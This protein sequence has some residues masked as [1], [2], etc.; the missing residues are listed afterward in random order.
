MPSPSLDANHKPSWPV[1]MFR[2]IG[3]RIDPEIYEQAQGGLSFTRY[4]LVKAAGGKFGEIDSGW[5]Q[6]AIE[7]PG[8]GN[9]I[10][11]D[12]LAGYSGQSVPS[13]WYQGCFR[14]RNIASFR[15]IRCE[16]TFLAMY[17]AKSIS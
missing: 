13:G 5:N 8:G 11:P 14:C 6:F 12:M 17:S 3:T 4:G 16:R 7:R 1:R 2:K 15:A 10:D 9:H